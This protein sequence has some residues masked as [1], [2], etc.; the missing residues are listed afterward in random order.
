METIGNRIFNSIMAMIL[1]RYF[2]KKNV[3]NYRRVL[4]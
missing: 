3:A 1:D 4:V 2:Y